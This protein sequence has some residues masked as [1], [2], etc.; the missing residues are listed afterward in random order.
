MYLVENLPVILTKTDHAI[1]EVLARKVRTASIKQIARQWFNGSVAYAVRRHS[2]LEKEGLVEICALLAAEPETPAEA[3]AVWSPGEPLP[4]FGHL[5]YLL[6]TRWS[7]LDVQMT[8]C[9]IATKRYARSV[10]G[11]GGRISRPSEGTH[12]LALA[13][14]FFRQSE[15]RQRWWKQEVGKTAQGIKKPD[16]LLTGPQVVAIE[17]GGSS[18]TRDKLAGLWAWCQG[19][20]MGLELW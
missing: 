4:D 2:M 16:V 8:K 5:A 7:D 13:G 20:G 17:Q 6:N 12:D 9:V 1:L 10:A 11:Q 15:D 14:L 18:Y 3:L 19:Q